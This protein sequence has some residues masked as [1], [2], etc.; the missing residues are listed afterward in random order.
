MFK[1]T[2]ENILMQNKKPIFSYS[3]T[4]VVQFIAVALAYYYA[5][6]LE[7]YLELAETQPPGVTLLYVAL[8]PWLF[9]FPCLTL[10]W[11][12][13]LVVANRVLYFNYIILVSLV[14]VFLI[15]ALTVVGISQLFMLSACL[16]C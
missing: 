5:R 9:I 16:L 2:G 6:K 1:L 10:I 3:L 14:I 12:T 4:I 8:S 15:L 11:Y 13:R 7:F